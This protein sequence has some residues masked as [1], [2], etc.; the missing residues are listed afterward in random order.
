MIGGSSPGRGWEFFSSPPRPY[1]VWGPTSLLSGGYQELFPGDK[2]AGGVKLTTHLHLVQR[3][4]MRG[5]MS[6]LPQYFFMAWCLVKAQGQGIF[7]NIVDRSCMDS[8]HL[9]YTPIKIQFSSI[10]DEIWGQTD[11]RTNERTQVPH[12]TFI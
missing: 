11:G 8:A 6:L 2:A 3:L 10:G 12:Y 7:F 4:R 5:A 9:Y 1:R